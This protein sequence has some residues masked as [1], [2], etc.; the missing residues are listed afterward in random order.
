MGKRD[1]LA[2]HFASRDAA[3][4][5]DKVDLHPVR[6][7]HDSATDRPVSRT[8]KCRF[9]PK[10]LSTSSYV[11]ALSVEID[12]R[13]CVGRSASKLRRVSVT[14]GPKVQRLAANQDHIA[15]SRTK[16]LKQSADYRG[17]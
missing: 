15:S 3:R 4:R 1:R 13:A 12:V 11:L 8:I 17:I 6:G 16:L 9:A 14:L 7:G 2:W 5:R 10:Q